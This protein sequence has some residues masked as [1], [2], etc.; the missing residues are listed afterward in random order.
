MRVERKCC[1]PPRYT[2]QKLRGM[3]L[4]IVV[5]F[6]WS[7][8]QVGVT[9]LKLAEKSQSCDVNMLDINCVSLWKDAHEKLF[10]G[11]LIKVTNFKLHGTVFF[12]SFVFVQTHLVSLLFWRDF[13]L[14]SFLEDRVWHLWKKKNPLIEDQ[15]FPHH[16][17]FPM[18]STFWESYPITSQV[19]A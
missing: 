1:Y 11:Q 6:M 12:F 4:A 2:I 10:K 16:C 9:L 7:I 17:F 19:W 5:F 3:I 14:N 13:V 15:V 8:L 18:A